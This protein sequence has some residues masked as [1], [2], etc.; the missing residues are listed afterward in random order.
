MQ[1]DARLFPVTLDRALRHTTQGANFGEG[2]AA[3]ELQ[4]DNFRQRR[5]Y[6]RELFERIGNVLQRSR[7]SAL[8][9]TGGAERGDFEESPT[10]LRLTLAGIV[11]DEAAH[12]VS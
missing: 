3:V 5:L 6:S 9:A 10:L 8:R 1:V 2:Q 4:I 7:V 11:N 12:G